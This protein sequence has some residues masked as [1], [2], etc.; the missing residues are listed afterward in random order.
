MTRMARTS[1]K[2]QAQ[3]GKPFVDRFA[4]LLAQFKA[5][6]KA[7]L[8]G[9]GNVA[10]S[11]ART[12]ET[13]DALLL[14]LFDDLLVLARRHKG[15]PE[16]AADYFDQSIV[17]RSNGAAQPAPKPATGKPATAVA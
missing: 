5:T 1:A 15:E 10:S 6:R 12:K 16:R 7:Q 14:Q 17:R 9:K 11:N 3:L 13:R 2:Y 4:G 8:E